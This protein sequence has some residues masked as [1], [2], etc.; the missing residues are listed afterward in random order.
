MVTRIKC[1]DKGKELC[2]L[3]SPI[4]R[5]AIVSWKGRD[6]AIGVYSW[7]PL[8]GSQSFPDETSRLPEGDAQAFP[9][10]MQT[11]GGRSLSCPAGQPGWVSS[12]GKGCGEACCGD[13]GES[14]KSEEIPPPR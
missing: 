3:Q 6:G 9:T 12:W 10:S 5:S 7:C 1:R 11:V 13:L 8:P 2:K 4:Q 14:R